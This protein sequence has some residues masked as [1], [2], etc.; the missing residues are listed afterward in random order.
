[1][2]TVGVAILLNALIDAAQ[3]SI[4]SQDAHHLQKVLFISILY[5]VCLG[6]LIF[7]QIDTKPAISENVYLR[8]VLY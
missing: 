8:C 6:V 7:C 4:T 1:M 3:I 5:A 2:A